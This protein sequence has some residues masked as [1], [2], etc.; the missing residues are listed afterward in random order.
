MKRV[1]TETGRRL[2]GLVDPRQR[3]ANLMINAA[4]RGEGDTAFVWMWPDAEIDALMAEIDD[5]ICHAPGGNLGIDDFL[6]VIRIWGR[7][8]V[9]G[10]TIADCLDGRPLLRE[11]RLDGFDR[12]YDWN[13]GQ[14][15]ARV[16]DIL[17][18]HVPTPEAPYVTV[19]LLSLGVI[20][21]KLVQQGRLAVRP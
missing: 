15:K 14:T 21:V 11:Y 9:D 19:A 12:Y 17:Q 20:A 3:V 10:E 8:P 1:L 6:M 4:E 16:R 13:R 18:A 7:H 5:E 2:R